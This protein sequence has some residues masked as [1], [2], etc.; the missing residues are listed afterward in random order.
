[1]EKIPYSHVSIL[2]SDWLYVSFRKCFFD[3]ESTFSTIRTICLTFLF[4]LARF[5]ACSEQTI[6]QKQGLVQSGLA[7][8]DPVDDLVNHKIGRFPAS[9]TGN[10]QSADQRFNG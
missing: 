1:M 2:L 3:V 8:S 7:R 5:S 6:R 9:I 10:R 4:N